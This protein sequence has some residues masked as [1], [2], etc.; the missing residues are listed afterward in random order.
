M[1]DRVKSS[2]MGGGNSEAVR[3]CCCLK[4][5]GSLVDFVDASVDVVEVGRSTMSEVVGG[6]FESRIVDELAIEERSTTSPVVDGGCE[7][8]VDLSGAMSRSGANATFF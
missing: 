5:D 4:R 3:D 8:V 2:D 1:D 6:R 7:D